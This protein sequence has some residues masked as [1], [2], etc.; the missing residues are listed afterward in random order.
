M[1]YWQI[2]KIIIEDELRGNYRAD[3]GKEDLK[4]LSE[5]LTS[6]FG[7]GFDIT[8]LRK[9]KRFYS[10]YLKRDAVRLELSWTHYRLLCTCVT[11]GA[12]GLSLN[13]KCKMENLKL[14]SS[15]QNEQNELEFGNTHF[16]FVNPSIPLSVIPSP[17]SL[18]PI[19]NSKLKITQPRNYLVMSNELRV[20]S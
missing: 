3:Y 19:Q 8:N 4:F 17:V 14:F 20:M 15:E 10:L 9:M 1:T 6:D 5:R 13:V 18:I 11:R 12:G 2:G 16:L 7:R